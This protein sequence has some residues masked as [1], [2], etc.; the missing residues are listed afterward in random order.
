[1]TGKELA[2]FAAFFVAW[3]VLNRWLLPWFGV[4]TCMSGGCAL[5]PP[6]VERP[7]DTL[8]PSE[9]L[10]TSEGEIKPITT[11]PQHGGSQQQAP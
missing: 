8:M 10:L 11:P 7:T 3:I 9:P 5:P 6:P 4:R 2:F 1:M